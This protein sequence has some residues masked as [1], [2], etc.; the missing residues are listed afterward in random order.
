MKTAGRK[1]S[2]HMSVNMKK[3]HDKMKEEKMEF[4]FSILAFFY[5]RLSVL[6]ELNC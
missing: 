2:Q 5:F 1:G 3:T 4:Q 6:N